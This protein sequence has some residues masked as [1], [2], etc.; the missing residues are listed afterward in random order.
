V[1]VEVTIAR[2][3]VFLC[4]V[5]RVSLWVYS[6]AACRKGNKGHGRET[7]GRS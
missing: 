4:S 1:K 5:S 3:C 2:G 6:G 7:R